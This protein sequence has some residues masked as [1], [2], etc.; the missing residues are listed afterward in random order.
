MNENKKDILIKLASIIRDIINYFISS[1][2]IR[3]EQTIYFIYKVNYYNDDSNENSGKRFEGQF[4]FIRKDDVQ[5]GTIFKINDSIINDD[6]FKKLIENLENEIPNNFNFLYQFIGRY[7]KAYFN[8]S[9]EKFVENEFIETFIKVEIKEPIKYKIK[10]E[11][12]GIEIKSNI[13]IKLNNDTS[14]LFRK[15]EKEDFEQTIKAYEIITQEIKPYLNNFIIEAKLQPKTILEINATIKD[16]MNY[17]EVIELVNKSLTILRIYLPI[18]SNIIY[19]EIFSRYSFL[20]KNFWDLK[21][22]DIVSFSSRISKINDDLIDNFIKYFLKMYD[23]IPDYLY[24]DNNNIINSNLVAFKCYKKALLYDLSFEEIIV[25][26][27]MGL[28][29][30]YLNDNKELGFKLSI[31]IS[32]IMS[33]IDKDPLYIKEIINLCYEIRSYYVHGQDKKKKIDN[34]MKRKNITYKELINQLLDY[35][36]ISIIISFLLKLSKSDFIIKIENSLIDD[37][38]NNELRDL[39]R[40]ILCDYHINYHN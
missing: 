21:S 39:I 38:K 1:G 7:T 13:E 35:L 32:K 33:Y 4:N 10:I 20:P 27:T 11:L 34:K 40:K 16:I 18:S 28:E 31:F 17:S 8:E 2:K 22:Q 25:N 14:F 26:G 15:I 29:A 19:H 3:L 6:R 24:N 37:N 23:I 9:N 5:P 30:I 36:R 12:S